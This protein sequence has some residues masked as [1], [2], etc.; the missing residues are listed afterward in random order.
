MTKFCGKCGKAYDDDFNNC[1]SCG[2]KLKESQD[3]DK[4]IKKIRN[5]II[6]L[7]SVIIL[8]TVGIIFGDEITE[9]NQKLENNSDYSDYTTYVDPNSPVQ[10]RKNYDL[11]SFKN[12]CNVLDYKSISR[13]PETY[14]NKYFK[15]EGRIV[16]V[17][18]ENF[19]GTSKYRAST[20]KT[21]YLGYYDDDVYLKIDT[22]SSNSRIL[23]DDIITFY[24]VYK[25]TITY[26]TVL[27]A[28]VTVPSFEVVYWE[29]K[30]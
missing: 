6:I 27:H 7:I 13:S 3:N 17:V 23:E 18:D 8:V 9:L 26:T 29:L 19:Y 22:V 2:K 24:A 1:P 28:E 15:F 25:G 14:E 11:D 12:M 20:K 4:S 30:E 21:D 10:L 16:Q 5:I